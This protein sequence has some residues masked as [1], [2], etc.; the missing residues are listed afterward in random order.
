MEGRGR[1]V[2]GLVAGFAEELVVEL[3]KERVLDVKVRRQQE[4]LGTRDQLRN[5]HRRP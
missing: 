4:L 5:H 2:A 1:V 3:V